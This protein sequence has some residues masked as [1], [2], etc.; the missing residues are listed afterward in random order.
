MVYL[1]DIVKQLFLQA[2]C[3]DPDPNKCQG[4][5]D[6]ADYVLNHRIAF[7]ADLAW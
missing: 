7:P 4:A 1:F 5:Q 6:R 3:H 2:C